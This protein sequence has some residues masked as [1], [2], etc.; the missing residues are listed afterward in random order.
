M[1]DRSIELILRHLDGDLNDEETTELERLIAD[2]EQ[3]RET[4]VRFAVD[5]RTLAER[6]GRSTPTVPA[7]GSLDR[8]NDDDNIGSHRIGDGIAEDGHANEETPPRPTTA[9]SSGSTTHEP[10][11]PRHRRQLHPVI[12]PFAAAAAV[13][14][15]AVTVWRMFPPASS[16]D[17][18]SSSDGLLVLAP[19][20]R[21]RLPTATLIARS[22]TRLRVQRRRRADEVTRL[23]VV[24]GDVV[25]DVAENETGVI[26]DTPAGTLRDV[27]TR[28][29][30]QVRPSGFPETAPLREDSPIML[31]STA[32]AAIGLVLVSVLTGEVRFTPA[33]SSSAP[34]TLRHTMGDVTLNEDGYIGRVSDREGL[35]HVRPRNRE[36]WTL[37]RPTDPLEPGDLLRTGARGPNACVVELAN[38]TRLTIGP[39]SQIELVDLA[40]VRLV[41]GDVEVNAPKDVE[42]RVVG[43]D[44]TTVTVKDQTRNLRGRDG[45]TVTRDAAP[46]WLTAWRDDASTEAMG[47]LLAL[48]DGRN[49]PLTMGYHKVTVD[50]RDQ[51]ARTV[52]EE[53]FIN[54]T[55]TRLE[56]VFYFPLPADASISGF[57]MWI[58]GEK[59]KGEIVEKQRAREIYETILRE[60][61]D[62]A[63][64]EWTGGN[65]FKARVFPIDYEKRI[66]IRYT[67]VLPKRG[68]TYRYAYGLR[69]EMLRLNPLARLELNMTV[70]SGTPLEAIRC[71]SHP[72][73]VQL[74]DNSARLDFSAEEYTPT[75]DF[76]VEIETKPDADPV[77]VRT[78]RRGADGY[79]LALIDAPAPPDDGRGLV[80]DGDPLDIIV[81]ADTSGS[82]AGDP[83]RIQ[84]RALDA[85]VATLG[86]RDR[87]RVATV[88]TEV[89]WYEPDVSRNAADRRRG[90]IEFV[91]ARIP[92]GWSRLQEGFR[93]A[94]DRLDENTHLVYLGDGIVTAGATDPNLNA[95][96]LRSGFPGRGHVHTISCGA[97]SETAVLNALAKLGQGSTRELRD[98]ADIA[99]ATRDLFDAFTQPAVRDLEVTFDGVAVAATYPAELPHLPAGTQAVV[100]GRYD[101]TQGDGTGTIRVRAEYDGRPF[102]HDVDFELVADEAGNSFIPRLWARRRLAHLMTQGAT[103]EIRDQIIRLSE[104]YQI[105]TPYT[106]FLV[107]ESEADRRRFKVK[108]R[109]AIRD[110]EDFFA[111]GRDDADFELRKKQMLEAKQW[112]L[113]LRKAIL[114][115]LE[116]MS[117]DVVWQL[118]GGPQAEA[119]MAMGMGGGGGG[120][121]GRT[122]KTYTALRG[123]SPAYHSLQGNTRTRSFDIAGDAYGSNELLDV[124]ILHEAM[125]ADFDTSDSLFDA[126]R[127]EA[128]DIGFERLGE[129]RKRVAHY[130]RPRFRQQQRTPGGFQLENGVFDYYEL[131]SRMPSLPWELAGIVPAEPSSDQPDTRGPRS[132]RWSREVRDIVTDFSRRN[133]IAKLS[134]GLRFNVRNTA[135]D[136]RGA[137]RSIL[138]STSWLGSDRWWTTAP[139][140]RCH[141]SLLPVAHSRSTRDTER[142]IR[143]RTRPSS[144]RRRRERLG[145]AV[146]ILV[147]RTRSSFRQPRGDGDEDRR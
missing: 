29:R 67:Q 14:L 12:L 95:D 19:G 52:I 11:V 90:A 1:D 128:I 26:V 56:G 73:R 69:S 126:L 62:P 65:I 63:L 32:Y 127:D 36:R 20:E 66:E 140:S 145:R 43:P 124:P 94:F 9:T 70:S 46:S 101:P 83:R 86:E 72:C 123:A 35:A 79:L 92:L 3:A 120:N 27:G 22:E 64:L 51:I 71:P 6:L 33:E 106:S 8:E 28:F 85:L 80:R 138:D 137:V 31:R 50:I 38:G 68:S 47:S 131:Q 99:G 23:D 59:V 103:S 130:R 105:I 116:E 108:K 119:P 18:D 55:S 81:L 48:V 54:R 34:W 61:R 88:D 117:R 4:L 118:A 109:F 115:R 15:L 96:R 78:H 141:R 134:G 100:V 97:A 13:A 17:F 129:S 45:K 60:K 91:E 39:K 77:V 7:I 135:F 132:R 75:R 37:V 41:D 76:L 30:V 24:A 74:A 2:D 143:Y 139:H 112:R 114:A 104:D 89:R 5:E 107:L 113:R 125:S 121:W 82:M 44:D 57:S 40:T 142:V 133:L 136:P 87:L 10:H 147:S 93:E 42:V 110:G 21:H 16:S 84:L 144:A 111:E 122:T 25:V 49:V 53:S 146:R 58:G 98:E 102:A